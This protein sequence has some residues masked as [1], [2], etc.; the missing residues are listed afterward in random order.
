MEEISCLLVHPPCF[1]VG[2]VTILFDPIAQKRRK[3]QNLFKMQT[4]HFSLGLESLHEKDFCSSYYFGKAFA[5]LAHFK[6]TISFHFNDE[7]TKK[8]SIL[9]HLFYSAHIISYAGKGNIYNSTF[10]MQSPQ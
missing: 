2:D 3:I 6:D 8:K 4:S 10:A 5:L 9:F 1:L 7:N